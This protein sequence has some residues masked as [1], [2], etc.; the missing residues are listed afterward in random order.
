MAAELD[1]NRSW[2]AIGKWVVVG[3]APRLMT[4]L[5]FPLLR[6]LLISKGTEHRS[7]ASRWAQGHRGGDQAGNKLH[8]PAA[9]RTRSRPVAGLCIPKGRLSCLVRR[10]RPVWSASLQLGMAFDRSKWSV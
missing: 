4:C 7:S 9:P 2:P 1:L 3:G 8:E 5:N 10:S 6:V